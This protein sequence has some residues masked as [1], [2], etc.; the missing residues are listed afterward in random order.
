M[1][2]DD[3]KTLLIRMRYHTIPLAEIFRC[4]SLHIIPGNNAKLLPH[5]GDARD[6]LKLIQ[7]IQRVQVGRLGISIFSEGI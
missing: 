4:P 5:L 2:A 7:T 6:L 1:D 3:D